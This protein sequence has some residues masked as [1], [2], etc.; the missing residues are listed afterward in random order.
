[1]GTLDDVRHQV[2]YETG[3]EMGISGRYNTVPG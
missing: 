3:M 2:A 1:M